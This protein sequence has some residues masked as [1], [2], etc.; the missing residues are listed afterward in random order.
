M[1]VRRLASDAREITALAVLDRDNC[2]AKINAE[3]GYD[4]QFTQQTRAVRALLKAQ[5]AH[6]IQFCYR[7][8][9]RVHECFL[10]VQRRHH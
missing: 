6:D 1:A 2:V 3:S 9:L 10:G 8:G 7:L 5:Y 4:P